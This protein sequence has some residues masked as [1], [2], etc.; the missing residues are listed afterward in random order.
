MRPSVRHH[1][2]MQSTANAWGLAV[3]P[4]KAV[5]GLETRGYSLRVNHKRLGGVG[6]CLRAGVDAETAEF[7]GELWR[8]SGASIS[9]R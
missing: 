5:P 7:I 9:D 8:S 6:D 1:F 2:W 3:L 4:T